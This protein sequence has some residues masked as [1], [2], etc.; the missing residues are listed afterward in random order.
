[1]GTLGN[2]RYLPLTAGAGW[3]LRID[4][5]TGPH[6]AKLVSAFDHSTTLSGSELFHI[7]HFGAGVTFEIPIWTGRILV[8]G[9]NGANHPSSRMAIPATVR[10]QTGI[11]SRSDLRTISTSA[12]LSSTINIPKGRITRR[13]VSVRRVKKFSL[14]W[15]RSIGGALHPRQAASLHPR[16]RLH[17][18]AASTLPRKL[19]L[20]EP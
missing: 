9:G 16:S 5:V 19:G 13:P 20:G 11:S 14:H 18:A 6:R 17:V 12:S 15:P 4:R 3:N 2:P 8:Y 10:L 7:A 1:M